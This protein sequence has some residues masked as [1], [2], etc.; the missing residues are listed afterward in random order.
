M[1]KI[2]LLVAVVI[3]ASFASCKKERSCVCTDTYDDGTSN[4][5]TYPST[6][7]SKKN[8][9]NACDNTKSTIGW[10]KCELK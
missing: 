6:K 2:T 9:Q 1:K 3:A 7:D 4:S 8:Q 5:Y 10:D